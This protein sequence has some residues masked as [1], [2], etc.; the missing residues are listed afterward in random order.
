MPELC[1]QSVPYATIQKFLTAL[2]YNDLYRDRNFMSKSMIKYLSL[3]T[4]LSMTFIQCHNSRAKEQ[5]S[6]MKSIYLNNFK[7]IYFRKL[8]QSGFNNSEEVKTIIKFDRSGFTEPVL[9][10]D[11]YHLIDSIVLLDNL[12]MTSDSANRIGNVAE[13]AEGK[14]VLAYILNRLESKWLDSLA[15]ERYKTSDVRNLYS[16]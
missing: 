6:E 16:E 15:K 7:L 11:D 9:T 3:L 8:L 13:G 14:H 2:N 1:K 5:Q 12:K 10:D 4:L